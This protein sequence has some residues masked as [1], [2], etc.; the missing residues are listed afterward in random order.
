MRRRSWYKGKGRKAGIKR[1]RKKEQ[2]NIYKKHNVCNLGLPPPV[3]L[4]L[5][6]SANMN[7]PLSTQKWPWLM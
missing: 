4:T 1:R 6:L 5:G 3:N 2:E 7:F